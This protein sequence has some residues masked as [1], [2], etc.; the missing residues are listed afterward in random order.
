MRLTFPLAVVFSLRY[1]EY[2]THQIIKLL[3]TDFD[4]PRPFV[5]LCQT[6]VYQR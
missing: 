5:L 1:T 4:L 2:G 3:K 6:S